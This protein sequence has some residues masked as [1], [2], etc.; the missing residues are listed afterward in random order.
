MLPV[1]YDAVTPGFFRTLRIPLLQG[2]G[3]E[4]SDGSDAG[5]VAVVNEAFVRRF[6]PD[7][8]PV[9]RRFLFGTAEGEDPPWI[10]IVGVVAD[11]RRSGLD[12]EAH[13]SAYLPL[14]QYSSPRMNIMVRTLTDPLGLVEPI[15]AAVAAVDPEQPLAEV[16]TLK[17]AVSR[18]V[19]DRRFVMLLLG[20]FAGVALSL[21]AIGIY[22]V[23]A[24]VVGQRAREI[25]IR[26]AL[27][28]RRQDV[29]R[30]VIGE[31]MVVVGVGLL[32]GLGGAVV[33]TRLLRGLLYQTSPLDPMTLLL[34]TAV[35]AAVALVANWLPAGRAARMDPMQ[36]L[37]HE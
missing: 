36:A 29:R 25:G 27:G 20:L 19:A 35:L 16:R 10:T 4:P 33:L 13:P 18:L 32:L 23:M 15:R 17:Q 9:G 37:R 11:A 21:A 3:I 31:G 22:G 2:R 7:G 8:R 30:L 6:L 28:A 34:G 12:R 24:Y 1:T 14:A 26:V 5:R